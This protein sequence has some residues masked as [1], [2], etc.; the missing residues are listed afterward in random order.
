MSTLM[1]IGKRINRVPISLDD[2]TFM[3]LSHAASYERKD[4]ATF[5]GHIVEQHVHGLKLRL[6]ADAF[7]GNEND[8][9]SE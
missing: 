1:K 8:C 5:V 4:L 2:Y 3:L 7:A 9:H 6:P